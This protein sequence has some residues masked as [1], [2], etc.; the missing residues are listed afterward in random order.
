MKMISTTMV[1]PSPKSLPM[2]APH[3]FAAKMPVSSLSPASEMMKMINPPMNAPI[4]WAT[5]YQMAR[6]SV[7][8]RLIQKPSVIAGLMWQPETCPIV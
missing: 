7:I 8:L 4:S 2:S 6:A 3:P 5:Q 1:A